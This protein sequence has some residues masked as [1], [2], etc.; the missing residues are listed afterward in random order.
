M[1]QR[2]IPSIAATDTHGSFLIAIVT[3][4]IIEDIKWPA[5][6]E[7]ENYEQSKSSA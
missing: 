4:A 3:S 1:C 5:C 7:K 6:S 2:R